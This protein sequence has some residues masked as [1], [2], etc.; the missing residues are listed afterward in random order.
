MVLLRTTKLIVAKGDN[1]YDDIKREWIPRISKFKT[2]EMIQL[3]M[4]KIRK[5]EVFMIFSILPE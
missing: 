3:I 1:K 4:I 5:N 2:S